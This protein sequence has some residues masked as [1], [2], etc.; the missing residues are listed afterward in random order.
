MHPGFRLEWM[1]SD[2]QPAPS[3]S[4]L[5][6]NGCLKVFF[7]FFPNLRFL[8]VG[9]TQ[10]IGECAA[11]KILMHQLFNGVE[12][13]LGEILWYGHEDAVNLFLRQPI[14]KAVPVDSFLGKR[15]KPLSAFSDGKI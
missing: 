3:K 2:S 5:V 6:S 10:P 15:I 7:L 4:G 12:C 11:N 9:D 8:G 1:F 14:V 13:G